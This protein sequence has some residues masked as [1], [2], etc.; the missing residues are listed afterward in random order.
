MPDLRETRHRLRVAMLAM[1]CL[2]VV[3]GI[4]LVSP[5][6]GSSKTRQRDLQQLSAE[7]R[8]KTKQVEPLRGLDKKV[9]LAKEQIDDFYKQ[10]IPDRQ[11]VI[12]DDLG[13]LAAKNGVK[14]GQVKYETKE[15]EAVGLTPILIEADCQG[16]YLQLVR[17]VNA[18]E[19]DKTFFIVNSVVLGD[20]QG[21]SVKLQMKLE[22][23]LRNGG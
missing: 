22:S 21:G 4:V 3:A 9:V 5:L 10:R 1:L 20:A 13:K 2:D 19:R 12:S 16:D 18:L 11:S 15:Q 6:V 14:L 17:F 23:Y 8:Q 7:R